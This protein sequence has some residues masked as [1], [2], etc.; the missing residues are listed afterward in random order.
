MAYHIS[1]KTGTMTTKV[2]TRSINYEL[3]RMSGR[4]IQLNLP[5]VRLVNTTA[6]GYFYRMLKDRDCDWAINIDED[7]FVVNSA[8]IL[9]LMD[10]MKKNDIVNAGMSDGIMVRPCNPAVTNPFFNILNLTAIREKF[11]LEEIK[12]FNY[13]EHRDAILAKLP[14][15]LL[16]VDEERLS[17][18]QEEPFY[19]F[20]LWM[21]YHFNTLYLDAE[22]HP[23]GLS[24]ILKNHDG[25]P[26]LYHS[27]FS[28][29]WRKDTQHTQRIEALYREVCNIHKITPLMPACWRKLTPIDRQWQII[30]RKANS[31]MTRMKLK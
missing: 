17:M 21:A 10:Y 15:Y 19:N 4:C 12:N 29:E 27:W 7:A 5:R 25:V 16:Q 28:R 20:L 22:M 30:Q 18:T 23:D 13:F 1:S 6:D 14:H 26:M 9:S 3:Y 31:A 8:A 24:T 2:F 11:N